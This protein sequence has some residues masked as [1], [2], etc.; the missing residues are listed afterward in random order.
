VIRRIVMVRLRPEHQAGRADLAADVLRLLLSRPM[1]ATAEVA[2]W[3]PEV[4]P[5][6]PGWDLVITVHF[7]GRQALEAYGLDEP[8]ARFVREQ[9]AP[10][11]SERSAFNLMSVADPG[12]T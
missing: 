11:V 6:H 7:D 3:D 2:I 4:Q 1:V 8:H 12:Q 5:E 10:R 9:L